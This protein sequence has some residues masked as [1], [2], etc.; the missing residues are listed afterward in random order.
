MCPLETIDL[1]FKVGE[2]NQKG[3]LNC[4]NSIFTSPTKFDVSV[5]YLSGFN[6]DGFGNTFYAAWIQE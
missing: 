6:G 3:G 2:L 5:L 4:V 1:N